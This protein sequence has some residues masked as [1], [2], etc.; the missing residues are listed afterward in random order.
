MYIDR[1]EPKNTQRFWNHSTKPFRERAI[2]IQGFLDEQN[3]RVIKETDAMI[4]HAR[5]YYSKNFREKETLSQNQDVIEFKKNLDEKLAELLS[6]PF[7]FSINDRHRSIHRLKT[8]TSSGHEKVSTK[9]LNSI[10]VSH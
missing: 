1:L 4:E 7:V 10:P 5:Q 9:L 2:P 3:N 6:K 8:K